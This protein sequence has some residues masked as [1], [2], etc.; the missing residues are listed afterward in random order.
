MP[1]VFALSRRKLGAAL[2]KSMAVSVLAV[3]ETKGAEDLV[4]QM[5]AARRRPDAAQLSRGT[6]P[7]ELPEDEEALAALGP[8]ALARLLGAKHPYSN[9]ADGLTAEEMRAK[10]RLRMLGVE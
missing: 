3:L 9:Q 2:Q 8:G 10:L 5:R 7:A 6:S 4:E 1:V